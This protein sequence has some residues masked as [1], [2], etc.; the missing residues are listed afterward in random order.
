MAKFVFRLQSVLNLKA[1]LEDQQKN[2]FAATRKRLDDE[3][4]KLKNLYGRKAFY[5]EE[6]RTL[7]A[8]TLNIQD[9]MDNETS[10]K[11]IGEYI[12]DQTAQV[13]LWEKKLEEEREKLVEMMREH[14]TYER[15]REKA[16]EEYLENEKHEENVI[17]DEHNSYVYG[18]KTS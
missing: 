6:G 10:I 15:L 2:V 5:E 3:E 4:E 8:K 9:I 14:K 16:F 13:R 1:R 18:A 11:K 7:R 12:E 17:T